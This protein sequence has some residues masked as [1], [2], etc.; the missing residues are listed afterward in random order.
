MPWV[1]RDPKDHQVPT[2]LPQAGLPTSRSGTGPQGPIQPGLEHLRGWGIH[3]L[4][5]QLFQHLSTL[6]VKKF[7]LASNLNLP[8][9]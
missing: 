9:S 2:P 6:A 5:G 1:G 8:L 7:P 4:S 3:N